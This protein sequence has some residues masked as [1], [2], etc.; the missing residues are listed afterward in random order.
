MTE[1]RRLEVSV[2]EAT[3]G[4]QTEEGAKQ[5]IQ[6]GYEHRA[7][8]ELRSTGPANVEVSAAVEFLYPTALVPESV[9]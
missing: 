1:H 2:V 8:S 5:P 3:A 7:P 4:E 9:R 6:H